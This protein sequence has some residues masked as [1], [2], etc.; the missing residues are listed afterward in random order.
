MFMVSCYAKDELN[1][2][3]KMYHHQGNL[4]DNIS[5]YFTKDPVCNKLPQKNLDKTNKSYESL[6]LFFPMTIVQDQEVKQLVKKLHE[7]PKNGYSITF[8][9]VTKPIKGIKVVIGY[10]S[11]K[12]I[13]DYQMY[14]AI[15]GNKGIVFSFHNKQLL[16]KLKVSTDPLLQYA[17]N[18]TEKPKIMLDIGHGGSDQGKVGCFNVEEKNINFQVGSRIAT[19]L[20]QSGCEVYLTRYG[21]YF[22]ALDNRTADA[23]KKKVDLFLSIHANAG[24]SNAVGIETYCLDSALFKGYLKHDECLQKI[25]ARRDF[26]NYSFAQSVHAAALEA[27]KKVY[28]VTDRKVKRTVSQVLLGTDLMIPSA[29]IEIGF[30]SNHDETKLLMNKNYQAILA[31]GIAKGVLHYLKLPFFLEV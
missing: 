4:T 28:K 27:A 6:M 17:W 3:T 20:K 11:Q 12:I 5:C 18:G 31:Q 30:L 22:V 29:L 13:F 14:N 1:H 15:T 2:I 21:D 25:L 24:A 19:L 9:E 23:N 8:Q 10:D 7:A 16:T 26:L